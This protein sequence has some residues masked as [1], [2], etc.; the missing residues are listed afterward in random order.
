M[1]NSVRNT[2][3][4]VLN[5]NNYGYISPSDFNLFAKQ[6]QIEIFEG[7][8]S[9]YN[10]QI[11]KENARKS[12][13]DDANIAQ[14]I[15]ETIEKFST[16]SVL[17]PIVDG[18]VSHYMTLPED[19]FM[20]QKMNYHQ[21]ILTSGS[22]TTP[23]TSGQELKDSGATFLSDGISQGDIAVNLTTGDVAYVISIVSD[24]AIQLTNSIY[25]DANSYAIL[26][27]VG[28][29]PIEK[30]SQ[31]KITLLTNSNHTAPTVTYPAYVLSESE[32]ASTGEIVALYP[33]TVA[34]PGSVVVQYVRYPRDPKWTYAD[35]PSADGEP[36]FDSTQSDYQ[37]FELP[38]LSEH[39]LVLKIL[40]YAG[41][42]IREENVVGI[43]AKL[44]DRETNLER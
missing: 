43:A 44:E 23:P 15:A 41:I 6:A 10:Y 38:I 25:E 35:V 8:F 18:E 40:E 5:K 31:S 14:S 33:I 28:V 17:L 9:R 29:R 4:S 19:Y 36:L 1:I 12:G 26:S 21:T 30:V 37:D 34:Q 24:I 11:N 22:I 13:T 16:S 32:S 20:I 27:L 2:V 39:T 7:Y 3:L 42:S